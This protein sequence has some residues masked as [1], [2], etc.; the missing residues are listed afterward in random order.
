MGELEFV[1]V[2]ARCRP[3]S[4]DNLPL[5]GEDDV[6]GLVL[7]TGHGRNGLLLSRLTAEVVAAVVSCPVS[8]SRPLGGFRGASVE[9]ALEGVVLVGVAAAGRGT[10]G[11]RR[12]GAVPRVPVGQ[13]GHRAEPRRR[14]VAW[15]RTEP[16]TPNGEH[17][18]EQRVPRRSARFPP[19]SSPVHHTLRPQENWVRIRTSTGADGAAMQVAARDAPVDHPPKTS[20]EPPCPCPP[21]RAG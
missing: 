8:T 15:S 4:P 17:L 19:A 3:G 12:R 14:T 18:V 21:V 1:E 20:G 7:A 6:A 11:A 13:S 2:A 10:R 5:I 9:D 16:L